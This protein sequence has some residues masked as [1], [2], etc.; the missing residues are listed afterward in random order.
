MDIFD[1]ILVS[2][3]QSPQYSGMHQTTAT[4]P[5]QVEQQQITGSTSNSAATASVAT[6]A[7][8]SASGPA[9]VAESFPWVDSFDVL[10]SLIGLLAAIEKENNSSSV[11]DSRHENE[12]EI[13]RQVRHVLL[14]YERC[15]CVCVCVCVFVYTCVVSL[16]VLST[17]DCCDMPRGR[18]CP[19]CIT[20]CVWC[21]QWSIL[22]S[23]DDVFKSDTF[24]CFTRII[25]HSML[26]FHTVHLSSTHSFAKHTHTHTHTSAHIH[27]HI[28]IH[29]HTYILSLLFT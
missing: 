17:C 11:M 20:V 24:S 22:F 2:N 8:S 27:I 9:V 12:R 4:V 18:V 13:I 1:D 19:S 16:S 5:P 26:Y 3:V 14:H 29:T 23:L 15:V 21:S 7:T 28:H 25:D 6:T 10:P